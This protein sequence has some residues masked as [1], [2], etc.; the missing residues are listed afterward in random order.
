M[1]VPVYSDFSGGLRSNGEASKIKQNETPDGV[2]G[3]ATPSGSLVLIPG[4]QKVMDDSSTHATKKITMLANYKK[5]TGSTEVLVA[6]DGVVKKL[7]M[8]T[9]AV[10]DLP[11]P[12]SGHDTGVRYGYSSYDDKFYFCNGVNDMIEYDG[13]TNITKTLTNVGGTTFKTNVFAVFERK[14]YAVDY[15]NTLLL[16]RSRTDNV[17]TFNYTGGDVIENSGT[18]RI[19]EGNS[20]ITALEVNDNMYIFSKNNIYNPNYST[21]GAS[22]VFTIDNISRGA[23]AINNE[24]TISVGD[25][26]IFFDSNDR[27]ISQLGYKQNFP[28]VQVNGISEAIRNL[29][30]DTYDLSESTGIYWK[31]KYLIACKSTSI[32]PAN[33]IVVIVDL[34]YKS[35]YVRSGWFVNCWMEYNGDLYYG[36]SIGPFVYKAYTGYDDDGAMIPL[37]WSLKIDDFGEPASYKNCEFIYVE[38]TIDDTQKLNIT[39]RID[40]NRDSFTKLIDGSDT[41][42]IIDTNVTGE[43][44]KN[45]LGL[46]TLGG[47]E[48]ESERVFQVWVRCNIRKFNNMQINF[49]NDG[50]PGRISIRKVEPIN[51]SLDT[52]QP[53]SNRII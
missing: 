31:R 17:M 40:N 9:G 13:S 38:G 11:T 21:V 47:I 3:I 42:Y 19:A 24:S 6:Y 43:L 53:P 44:G 48:G 51:V 26:V 10:S 2:N 12:I 36:S 29:L 5:S 1:K 8:S 7:N 35:I 28:N 50:T 14:M 32:Q 34:D 15:S 37:S 39:V 25:A 45:E 16:H 49:T 30:Q 41:N 20:P 4:S 22:T 46:Y 27:N 52:T 33:D 23:G 18:T